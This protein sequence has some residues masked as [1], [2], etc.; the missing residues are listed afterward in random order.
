MRYAVAGFDWND[1]KFFLEVARIG[2]L[3]GAARVLGAD[4]AT[5]GRRIAALEHGLGKSLFHRSASGYTLTPA[6]E[7]LLGPAEQM[8]ALALRSAAD[9][10]QRGTAIGGVVRLVT[11]DGFGNF[12][13][14]ERLQQF[15]QLHPRLTV[16]MVPIQQIQAQA[17]RE[18]E[19][20][21]TLSAGGP[22]FSAERLGD[23]GLGLYASH[24]YLEAS[25]EPQ[26]REA[27]KSH[28][29][30]GYIEDL[31][32]ARE[33]DYLDEVQPALRAQVQCSSLLA[34]VEATE[35]GTG[36]CVLPHYV[37]RRRARLRPV[38]ADSVEIRRSYWMNI[39]AGA[40]RTPRIRAL[41]E[42]VRKVVGEFAF[43]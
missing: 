34:Q 25:G 28:R 5:V 9:G 21:I 24:G 37:A 16:Q 30:V 38:L 18:G 3:S 32:F 33:L 41:A 2:T 13:L 7:G 8:E 6:G 27:L 29:F 19:I 4:H 15:A 22:R 17:Q 10:E 40:E 39:L 36:I 26:S 42:F 1:L 31:L 20:S 11:A 35:A 12:F 23:Y 43:D 14:A